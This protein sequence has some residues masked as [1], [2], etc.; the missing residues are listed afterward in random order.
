MSNHIIVRNMQPQLPSISKTTENYSVCCSSTLHIA[1]GHAPMHLV[2]MQILCAVN[3]EA[4]VL[5][6]DI[7]VA[8]LYGAAK[9]IT[10]IK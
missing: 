6:N 9:Y 4:A 2:V 8:V 3:S 1:A 5:I 10:L 7:H